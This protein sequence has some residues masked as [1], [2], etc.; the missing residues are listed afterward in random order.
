M[1]ESPKLA[2]LVSRTAEVLRKH[3]ASRP[4]GEKVSGERELSKQLRISRP[5]LSAALN[6]LEREGFLRTRPKSGRVLVRR[7]SRT[8]RSFSNNVALIL[9]GALSE[10]EPRVLFWID[11]L[12][13][14][15][16]KEQ[17]QLEVLSRPNL[18]TARS[19]HGLEELVQRVKPSAWVLVRSTQ[20]MQEWFA[21]RQLPAVIAGSRYEGV[22]LTA[23]DRDHSAA[24]QHA[25]GQF[26]A[27]GHHFLALVMPKN[28]AA[29]DL[30]SKAGLQ[31]GGAQA[32][33]NIET[34]IARHDGTVEGICT[35]VNR[36]LT[37]QSPPTAFLVA[38]ARYALTV[39][40][41]LIQRGLRFPKEVAMISRDHDSFLED[42]VPSIAR[43]RVAPEVFAQKLS[44]VV[45]ELTV[46]GNPRPKEHLLMPK[47]IPG[48]TLG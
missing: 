10:M 19:E 42:V 40:G 5:T 18:Y 11:E 3:F 44:H 39:H 9:P 48:Q 46:G 35:S 38:Q 16:A 31:T 15:L 27:R 33:P 24:C 28:A 22:R 26:V 43:Y 47:L 1:I 12:R 13:E 45:M 21:A 37:R 25:V 17:H 34:M 23:V 36:L 41:Y 8:A 20:A 7:R 30:K 6:L 32:G 2:T 29:G 4:A 14:A